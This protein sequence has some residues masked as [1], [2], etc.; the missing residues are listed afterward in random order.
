MNPTPE[1]QQSPAQPI[2]ASEQER[3]TVVDE[4]RQHCAAGRLTADELADRAR[5]AYAA[6]TIAELAALVND[7]PGSALPPPASSGQPR[8]RRTFGC[9]CR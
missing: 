2:R 8:A 7:L 4:L 5:C 3:E 1:A 6:R 9:W